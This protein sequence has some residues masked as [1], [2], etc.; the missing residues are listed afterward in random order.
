LLRRLSG[1]LDELLVREARRR[2]LVFRDLWKY[3]VE[4]KGVV[5]GLDAGARVF[6]FGSVAAGDYTFASDVDVLIVTDLKPSYVIAVLRR[7]GFEEPFEFHVMSNEEFRLYAPRIKS[8][9][10]V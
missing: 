8:L 4:I 2:L 1:L 9:R 6:L 3:L 10:E 7:C 5:V